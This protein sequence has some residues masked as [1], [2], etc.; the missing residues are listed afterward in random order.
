MGQG[1]F[2][3]IKVIFYLK[4][5]SRGIANMLKNQEEYLHLKAV[6]FKQAIHKRKRLWRS[7]WTVIAF[8]SLVLAIGIWWD[9]V[10]RQAHRK[11]EY[12][13]E[14][15]LHLL[16]KENGKVQYSELQN[17]EL[18]HGLSASDY[19]LLCAQTGLSKVAI[20]AMYEQ[21]RKQELL[22]LQEKL[23]ADVQIAC[24]ANTIISREEKL[25]DTTACIPYVENGDILISFNCHAIGW[26]N[27]H[28]A[29]VV[30]A[31]NRQTLE[32]RVLGSNSK[33]ISM[34]HW[35]K[36]PSFVVLRLKGVSRQERQQIAEYAKENLVD[37]P[38]RLEAGIVEGITGWGQ[39]FIQGWIQGSMLQKDEGA[40]V[41]VSGTHCAHLVWSAYN[42]FGYNLDSD[43]G[44]IVTP[45][46]I[47]QSP[48][49]EVI[50]IYGMPLKGL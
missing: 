19:S 38:Y 15:I 17:G 35:E 50:Q 16:Q 45:H 42:E 23:F 31:D 20:D 46:D 11:P 5:K 34:S 27:G 36:Y 49:L 44:L 7:L 14:S 24:N 40:E 22:I 47:Y 28:A 41:A 30:D 39:G 10:E 8:L 37:V 9:C 4:S 21:G 43:G 3:G 13:K 32:A 2:L 48:Y 18:Q 25:K 1:I 33:I 12:A 6:A 26:R 29:I